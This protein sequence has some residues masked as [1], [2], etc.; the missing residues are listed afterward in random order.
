MFDTLESI[1]N[2]FFL[3]IGPDNIRHF[4]RAPQV[5][6]NIRRQI[7]LINGS[8][9]PY[10]IGLDILVQQLIGVQFRA[11]RRKE[12]HPQILLLPLK[13]TGRLACLVCRVLIHD[14]DYLPANLS[15]ESLQKPDEYPCI[16][17][18]LE[19]HEI[20]PSPV[21]DGR[22]H[23]AAEAPSCAGDHGRLTPPAPGAA[24][25]VVG[26]QTHLVAPVD[27][28]PISLCPRLNCRVFLPKPLPY[29]LRVSLVCAAHRLLRRESPMAQ[30]ASHRPHRHLYPKPAPQELPYRFPRPQRERKLQLIRAAIADQPHGRGRLMRRKAL[31]RRPASPTR[32]QASKSAG[33]ALFYPV[34][35]R[36]T[37]YAECPRRLGL[38]H[39]P[40]HRR[41]NATAEVLLCMWGKKARILFGHELLY[42]PS[43]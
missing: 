13:P 40:Y 24:G 27:L 23:V 2:M 9:P 36:L 22:N 19:Y 28:G 30:V 20:K 10:C 8:S 33:A 5:T 7:G 43:K 18:L 32:S 11:V 6:S 17:P 14:Q 1:A 12:V 26:S 35:H 41:N 37:R 29:H 34:V 16:E 42:I 25:L 39:T 38:F 15:P 3:K 4:L 31:N 21:S